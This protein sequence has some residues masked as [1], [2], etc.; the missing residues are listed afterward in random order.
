MLEDREKMSPDDDKGHVCCKE[1]GQEICGENKEGDL[2]K[3]C[4]A[5][6]AGSEEYVHSLTGEVL[7]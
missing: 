3:E 5:D 1:G 6:V 7:A 4:A 2:M